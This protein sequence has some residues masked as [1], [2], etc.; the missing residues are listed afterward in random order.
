MLETLLF[1]SIGVL[2][3]T[4]WLMRRFPGFSV[5]IQALALA[6]LLP[7]SASAQDEWKPSDGPPPAGV[8]G[9]LE[10]ADKGADV[11]LIVVEAVVV[12]PYRTVSVGAQ[13][14]GA[15]EKFPFEEGDFVEEG[16][17]VVQIG[18]RRYELSAQRAEER[19][20]LMEV[21]H[22]R[23]QEEARIKKEIYDHDGTTKQEVLKAR[24][25]AEMSKIRIDEAK[26]ELDLAVYDLDSCKVTAP[27]SGYISAKN[28]QIGETTD[29]FEKIFTMVDS[30]KVH[31][32]AHVP[33]SLLPKIKKGMEATFVYSSDRKFKGVIERMGKIIDPKSR[34]K[35]VYLL[36]DNTDNEL[37][38]GMNGT[39]QLV[40]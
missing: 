31:A 34:T 10:T 15:I 9:P 22:D 5:I 13:V 39:L 38:V 1:L 18:T 30:S 24:A 26:K 25:E 27:F 19:M 4:D 8:S 23:A 12:N 21:A 40:R 16:A 3:E 7:V 20:K 37:E 36:I 29:R 6:L 2:A 11:S 35:K 17:L 28:K 32:V 14:G 33:E